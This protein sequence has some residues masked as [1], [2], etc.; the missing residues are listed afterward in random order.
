[1]DNQQRRQLM[2]SHQL[3]SL[4]FLRFSDHSG[5]SSNSDIDTSSKADDH[6]IVPQD[7]LQQVKDLLENNESPTTDPFLMEVKMPQ[8]VYVQD[9][10][11]ELLEPP[12]KEP[13][14]CIDLDSEDTTDEPTCTPLSMSLFVSTVNAS[15]ISQ[16]RH[17]LEEYLT[18]STPDKLFDPLTIPDKSSDL[19]NSECERVITGETDLRS[20][21]SDSLNLLVLNLQIEENRENMRVAEIDQKIEELQR[22]RKLVSERVVAL[23]QKQ[24]DAYHS[25]IE[26]LI[27]YSS[28]LLLHGKPEVNVFYRNLKILY[29]MIL[30]HIYFNFIQTANNKRVETPVSASLNYV[31]AHHQPPQLISL[32]QQLEDNGVDVAFGESSS[33]QS[34]SRKRERVSNDT[35]DRLNKKTSDTKSTESSGPSTVAADSSKPIP[36]ATSLVD[37]SQVSSSIESHVPKDS[38][39]MPSLPSSSTEPKKERNPREKEESVQKPTTGPATESKKSKKKNEEEKSL[40]EKTGKK[41]KLKN[42][43]PVEKATEDTTSK[44]PN[45]NAPS[46]SAA[47]IPQSVPVAPHPNQTV[48]MPATAPGNR[49]STPSVAA[50]VNQNVF[51]GLSMT[52]VKD[53]HDKGVRC[54]FVLGSVLFTAS[55]DGEFSFNLR[56]FLLQ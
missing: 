21:S 55:D 22:E 50:A 30:N 26:K 54:M 15:P 29:L 11:I 35:D 53:P 23:K 16:E 27:A 52:S 9:D 28:L 45:Y 42:K 34:E 44:P 46:V 51:K 13:P 37:S 12:V 49:L 43:S 20:T 17:V 32:M 6:F 18:K 31:N 39:A 24:I 19:P 25:A 47:V 40:N 41:K 38:I 33:E 10:E 36:T 48:D 1:M 2:Q 5:S 4:R 7:F 14:P 56:Y 8:K 3:P